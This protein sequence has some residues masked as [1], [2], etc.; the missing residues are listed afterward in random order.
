MLEMTHVDFLQTIPTTSLLMKSSMFRNELPRRRAAGYQQLLIGT[1]FAASCGE[2]DPKRD[3]KLHR[4]WRRPLP[5]THSRTCA[6]L[7]RGPAG[8]RLIIPTLEA[9]TTPCHS[10]PQAISHVSPNRHSHHPC[11]IPNLRRRVRNL[12]EHPNANGKDFSLR[13]T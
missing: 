4:V 9:T 10:P 6:V 2:L 12:P 8:E 1:F 13:S 5:E 11:V 3:S 7:A